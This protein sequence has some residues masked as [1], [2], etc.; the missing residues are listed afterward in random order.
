MAAQQACANMQR[1]QA[2]ETLMLLGGPPL[3]AVCEVCAGRSGR[4]VVSDHASVVFAARVGMADR[5]RDP[6][7]AARVLRPAV[8]GSA[9]LARAR[10]PRAPL[11]DTAPS[12]VRDRVCCACRTSPYRY[13]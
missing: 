10:P 9:A 5:A 6:E 12:F 8:G 3:L 13:A 2:R 1:R 7:D 4:W 11:T